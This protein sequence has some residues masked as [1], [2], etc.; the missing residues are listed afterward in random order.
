VYA[1]P[2]DPHPRLHC[3]DHNRDP[4]RPACEQEIE[5]VDWVHV[6]APHNQYDSM[7][8]RQSKSRYALKAI[9]MFNPGL[10]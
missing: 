1:N 2:Y 10:L 9:G 4:L 3:S 7:F 5:F 8:G 6:D